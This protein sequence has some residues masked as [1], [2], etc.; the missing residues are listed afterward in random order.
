VDDVP[1]C[2]SENRRMN[3]VD[4]AI[5]SRR[6]IRRF[7]PTPV[8]VET[9]EAILDVS[10]RAPSGTNMQPWRGYVLAGSAKDA[11]I[12]AVQAVFDAEEKGHAQEVQYYPDEFFEPYLSRRREVGWGLY[13]KLGIMRGEAAKMK[14]QHRRNFQF[15]DAPVGMIF[16][17]HRRLATGSWLD[18]GMFLENIMTAARGRGLDT[19]AQAAWTHYHRAIRPVLGLA[20][21]ETVV[22]GMAVGY[23]DPDAVENTLHTVRAPARSFV[24]FDGFA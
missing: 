5:A 20:D 10:A 14:A 11:L 8:P 18:Y 13:G 7:L 17:I 2:H 1:L 19:C 16:T 15:F 4:D 12:T 3:P 22:C 23:A 9:V 21:E 24:R 6:S